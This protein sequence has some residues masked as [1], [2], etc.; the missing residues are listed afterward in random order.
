[1]DHLS[2]ADHGNF[3]ERV[4][5]P[6]TRQVAPGTTRPDWS[7]LIAEPE[8]VGESV[9]TTAKEDAGRE[10]RHHLAREDVPEGSV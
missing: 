3:T 2:G 10:L 8:R 7:D 1:M 9:A 5:P 6:A 4:L